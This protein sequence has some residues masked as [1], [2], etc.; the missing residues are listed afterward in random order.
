M[1]SSEVAAVPVE[2]TP[3]AVEEQYEEQEPSLRPICT[4]V[5]PVVLSLVLFS[6]LGVLIRVHLT[7]LFTYTGEPVYGLI[8]AQMLG[9]FVMGA[10]MPLKGVLQSYSPALNTGVT[11]GL[12]GSITTFSSWQLL[13]FQEFF[14]TSRFGHSQ[15][16]NF[17]GGMSVLTTTL[18]C[19]VAA[20]RL[21]Q[22]VGDEVH[23]AYN[24]YLGSSAR[25]GPRLAKV[26]ER[27]DGWLAWDKWARLDVVLAA[28]G[29]ASVIAAAVVIA[30]APRTRSV[31]IALLFGPVGTL[32]RWRLASLNAEHSQFAGF[33]PRILSGLPLGTLIANVLGSAMLAI[34]HVLQTGAV[35]RPSTS[36][37]YI[38]A[39][40]S[41]G[42]CGCLTTISTF[43]AE[44]TVLQSRLSMLYAS[45]SIVVTQALFILVAGV[46][47]KTATVDYPVC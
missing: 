19:S 29:I 32:L 44:I 17:L 27:H 25:A 3:N 37:C 34:T 39:A 5:G 43:A 2:E 12:C 45:I 20:T 6:M 22:M 28:C 46:Y 42:F 23:I 40:V 41:D 24:H 14:N 36:S 21:G 47:F 7:R 30:L 8:W 31:S 16:S 13:L 10:A 15:F 33:V 1:P 35:V 18:G 11:T 9:C 4:F 38:L 26:A